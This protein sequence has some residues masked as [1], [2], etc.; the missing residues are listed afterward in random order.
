MFRVSMNTETKESFVR[1]KI[2]TVCEWA[3]NIEYYDGVWSIPRELYKSKSEQSMTAW[4][5]VIAKCKSFG[6]RCYAVEMGKGRKGFK[7]EGHVIER[8]VF[9]KVR[10]WPWPRVHNL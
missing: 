8:D 9:C 3:G 7:I 4:E 6:L 2:L 1:R 10:G 5:L